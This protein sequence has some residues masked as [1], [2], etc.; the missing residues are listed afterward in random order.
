MTDRKAWLWVDAHGQA[1]LSTG[2]RLYGPDLLPDAPVNPDTSLRE[3]LPAL[4]EAFASPTWDTL[5]LDISL[6]EPWQRLEWEALCMDGKALGQVC[7]VVRLAAGPSVRPDAPLDAPRGRV[8]VVTPLAADDQVR[9]AVNR[10][11]HH[12]SLR[13]VNHWG[14][15]KALGR[16]A[17]EWR[18]GRDLAAEF[19]DLVIFAHGGE[20]DASMVLDA[21]DRP[22]LDKHEELPRFPPRVWLF[23]CSNHQG[24]LTPLVQR[25]LERGAR[26]VLYG[27]G[28]LEADT[29]VEV[30]T[31][32]LQASHEALTSDMARTTGNSTLRLAG[33]VALAYPDQLTLEQDRNAGCDPLKRLKTSPLDLLGQRRKLDDLGP[34][35]GQCWPR[36][37]NWLL[38]YLAYFAEQQPGQDLRLRYQRQWEVL[39]ED[40]KQES[41]ATTHFLAA[42]ARRDGHYAQQSRYLDQLLEQCDAKPALRD[43]AFDALLSM[44][45][46]WIDMNLPQQNTKLIRKLDRLLGKLDALERQTQSIKLLDIKARQAMRQGKGSEA[47]AYYSQRIN[48]ESQEPSWN[49][50]NAARVHAAALYTAAW[51]QDGSAEE[52]AR[53]CLEILE[54]LAV[55]DR[56]YLCRALAIYCWRCP[57]GAHRI[58]AELACQQWLDFEGKQGTYRDFGPLAVTTAALLLCPLLDPLHR[59]RLASQWEGCLRVGLKEQ[60]YWLEL[61]NWSCLLGEQARAQE[62]LECFHEQR[63]DIVDELLETLPH[64][65]AEHDCAALELECRVRQEQETAM[66]ALAA[67]AVADWLRQGCMPL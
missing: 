27:H 3:V 9:Q 14:T 31:S 28:K 64:L 36:T 12:E 43:F 1:R 45:N 26:Q 66:L 52:R 10:L 11:V 47:L 5:V 63:Q 2:H 38:P 50:A 22:W 67:P 19:S 24:N 41:A 37:Q 34:V 61:A 54:K 39:D 16:I 35:V 29:M 30:F 25:M 62:A 58:A 56:A 6:P 55:Q 8:L 40:I 33:G 32:W 17:Q 21:Q 4:A 59:E 42:M 23:V 53:Q 13:D 18:P 20:S 51:L 65:Q 15:S 57:E 60:Y 44:A 46:L 48:R 49:P 7:S